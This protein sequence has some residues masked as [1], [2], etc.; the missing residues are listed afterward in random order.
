MDIDYEITHRIDEK[1][2]Q[3]VQN[4]DVE[5]RWYGDE[6]DNSFG[7]EIALFYKGNVVSINRL[8]FFENQR[9]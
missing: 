7:I 2:H 9:K 4:L 3:A 5:A 1:I 6:K 8:D